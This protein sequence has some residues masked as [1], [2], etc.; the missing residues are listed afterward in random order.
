MSHTSFIL[1]VKD[2][3]NPFETKQEVADYAYAWLDSEGFVGEGWFGGGH[4]DWYYIGGRFVHLMHDDTP[5]MATVA[6]VIERAIV[7]YNGEEK[8]VEICKEHESRDE[9]LSTDYEQEVELKVG[10]WLVVDY[11]L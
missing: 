3:G 7:Q 8:W 9:Y 1:N 11:H 5:K 6:E 10:D 4:C 2:T